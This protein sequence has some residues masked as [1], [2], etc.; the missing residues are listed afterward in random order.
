MAE[1]KPVVE[2]KVEAK[3]EEDKVL[4]AV[5]GNYSSEADE[6]KEQLIR[7][8]ANACAKANISPTATNKEGKSFP[9]P[10]Y[11]RIIGQSKAFA[12]DYF[13]GKFLN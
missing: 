3:V 13:K 8:V 12:T 1:N 11:N 10:V 2:A 5:V 4:T 9:N 7:A 6:K